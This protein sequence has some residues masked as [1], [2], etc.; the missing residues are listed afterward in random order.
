MSDPIVLSIAK[1]ILAPAIKL[2]GLVFKTIR[3][4]SF[5]YKRAPK[6]LFEHVKPGVSIDSVKEIL[7]TPNQKSENQYRYVFSDACVQVDFNDHSSVNAVS[8][9]LAN[10]SFWKRF[11]VW[12]I[13][14]LVLGKTTFAKIIDPDDEIHFDSSS[15]FY[16][17]YVIKSYGFPG[18]YWNYAVGVLECPRVST[19]KYHWSPELDQRSEIPPK[20]KVN[21]V[22]VTN[23][24]EPP[25]FSYFGFI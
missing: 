6:N 17:F 15:K 10:I 4:P 16:H 8:V 7:G 23:L 3:R 2:F 1:S 9:G 25:Y 18:F 12:P 20:M 22:C 21:W 14:D 11:Q 5:T 19:D 24:D 13:N